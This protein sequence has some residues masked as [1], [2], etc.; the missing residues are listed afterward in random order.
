[1]EIVAAT[2]A[3]WPPRWRDRV[4]PKSA[5]TTVGVCGRSGSTTGRGLRR[6][7]SVSRWQARA[8]RRALRPGGHLA[9]RALSRGRAARES[10]QG[11]CVGSSPRCGGA[12]PPGH[13]DALLP[14]RV[15]IP[16]RRT[17]TAGCCAALAWRVGH[18]AGKGPAG[19]RSGA[20]LHGNCACTGL[21]SPG[22]P[23]LL[24]KA[25]K[26][27]DSSSRQVRYRGQSALGRRARV[28]RR[29]S[30][31]ARAQGLRSGG[32]RAPE[33]PER[34]NNE[35]WAA[36]AGGWLSESESGFARGE[37]ETRVQGGTPLSRTRRAKLP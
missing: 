18:R 34:G 7:P 23:R 22:P 27:G 35:V 21:K 3:A 15:G 19:T 25:F 28:Q 16:G 8:W 10:G 4:P 31:L 17:P 30:S 1:M 5:P 2:H 33:W 20:S 37:W 32:E 24:K 13:W 29:L 14:T 11:S 6:C 26:R 9:V 36:V 12:L